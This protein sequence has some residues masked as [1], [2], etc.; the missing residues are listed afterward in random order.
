MLASAQV[1]LD[2]PFFVNLKG[3]FLTFC[4]SNSTSV[5]HV[6]E[7]LSVVQN[8]YCLV[9]LLNLKLEEDHHDL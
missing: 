1:L 8:M 3:L 7:D 4:Q 6:W 2:F 5:A 9:A